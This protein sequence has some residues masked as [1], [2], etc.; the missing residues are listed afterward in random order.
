MSLAA[1]LQLWITRKSWGL[2][3]VKVEGTL[4]TLAYMIGIYIQVTYNYHYTTS[5][6]RPSIHDCLKV[7]TKNY[8]FLCCTWS[9]Q[10]GLSSRNA[11]VWAR[12]WAPSVLTPHYHI[13]H[14]AVCACCNV[15][16]ASTSLDFRKSDRSLLF[17][18][19]QSHSQDQT[20]ET[21]HASDQ[22][23][24]SRTRRVPW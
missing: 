22:H 17:V 12:T 23:G 8:C 18:T 6:I 10:L 20:S 5:I 2:A 4:P 16:E 21:H 24:H 9:F 7:Q 13:S 1:W 11:R 15:Y 3:F 14:P 19:C